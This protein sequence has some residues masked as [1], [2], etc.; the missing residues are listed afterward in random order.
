MQAE[1]VEWGAQREKGVQRGTRD[2]RGKGIAR[3][4]VLDI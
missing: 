2:E 3:G 1:R 4:R